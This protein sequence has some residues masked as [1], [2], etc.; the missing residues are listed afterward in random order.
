[1]R[2][3]KNILVANRGEIAVRVMTTAQALGYKTIA[4][5]SEADATA[6]HV[7]MADDAVWIGPGPVGQ[8]YLDMDRILAAAKETGAQAVHPG[9]GFLSENADFARAC[10]AAGLVFIGPSAD[11][12]DLMGNK[13]AAKRRMI[14][15][16]V[17]CVPGYEDADQTDDVL[18]NAANNI[19]YPIMVKAAAGGG[20]RGMRLVD[21]AEG[22]PDALASARSEAL[23]AFGSD[24]LILEKAIIRPRH[25]EVQV[26]AD[27]HGNVIHLGERDCSVQ[28]RH[29]K[30]VEE[31]PCPV[32][33]ED[34]RARMGAAAVEA[35]RSIDY[36]GAGTVE[37]LLDDTGAYYFLEMNT[38]LQVEHP[39]TEMITGLDLVGLQIQVAEGHPLGISQ[40]DVK[41]SGHAIEVRLYAEDTTQDFLPCT[42]TIDLWQPAVGPGLRFD[43][44]IESGQE[45]SPFYDPMIA[46]AVAWGET[47]EVARHRLIEALKDTVLFGLTT[48]RGFLIDILGKDAFAKGE[49][50]TGF[51]ADEFDAAALA[52]PAP[53]EKEAAM[54]AVIQYETERQSAAGKSLNIAPSLMNWS[55]GGP[56]V[57]RYLYDLSAWDKGQ[58]ELTVSPAGPT[59]YQVQTGDDALSLELLQLNG[60]MARLRVDGRRHTV[61]FAVPTPGHIYLS[62]DG[63]TSNFRN[64]NA[65]PASVEEAAGGGRVVAPMHG[66]LLEI[67]VTVGDAVK[68]G[69]RLAVLEA[70]KMQHDIL[71]E[72]DGDVLEVHAKA[73]VQVAADDLLVEIEATDG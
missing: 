7:Q 39:V 63:K 42:G 12:I 36:R 67:S 65:F 45:I 31:A 70:M 40:D 69:D 19:G 54:A 33:T 27:S 62:L 34:L 18:I 59:T 66:T 20:G 35:A 3:F 14:A 23:N 46:K 56:L 9:Y 43:A 1:M 61:H 11:A 2:S 58:I 53:D 17:P 29:Q 32:M 52:E 64:R 47:R 49:A 50:T 57:T 72:V 15:A 55:S 10:D 48:N 37:F 38:R 44:G 41:L 24:E 13:A 22:L 60:N 8:S 5:Y 25:V 26:F 6:P 68:T 28:R 51:I 21:A 71:A 4:V 30:V 73:G 16:D